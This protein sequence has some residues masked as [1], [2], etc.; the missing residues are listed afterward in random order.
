MPSTLSAAGEV[1]SEP[2]GTFVGEM[3]GIAQHDGDF[4]AAAY[5][6]GGG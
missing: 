6:C 3:I 2:P 5:C 1:P 4:H